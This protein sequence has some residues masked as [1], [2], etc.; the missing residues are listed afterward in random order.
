MAP[1][2]IIFPMRGSTGS[3][4]YVGKKKRGGV[5]QCA[6][7]VVVAGSGRVRPFLRKHVS[8]GASVRAV[9]AKP[10]QRDQETH[11]RPL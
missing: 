2:S 10:S 6:R 7:W 5:Q 1:N 3:L 11:P 4:A 9:E 8:R